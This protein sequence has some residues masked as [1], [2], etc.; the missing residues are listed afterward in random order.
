MKPFFTKAFY[1][2]AITAII[3]S[4]NKDD[5]KN[6]TPTPTPTQIPVDYK[7]QMKN[8]WLLTNLTAKL[9]LDYDNDGDGETEI[10]AEMPP[11]EQDNMFSFISD[12]LYQA[13]EGATKCN[14]NDPD[15]LQTETWSINYPELFLGGQE[16]TIQMLDEHNLVFYFTAPAPGGDEQKI[17]YTFKR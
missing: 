10:Y 15:V 1:A 17:T 13:K 5:N 11:C 4:C 12:T 7:A 14:P 2:L 3:A 9:P 16:W 8:D 6:T